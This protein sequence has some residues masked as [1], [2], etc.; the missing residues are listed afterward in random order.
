VTSARRTRTADDGAPSSIATTY[1]YLALAIGCDHPT[2][3]P[4]R[5]SLAD[6]SEVELSGAGQ[7]AASPPGS[8]LAI[9]CDDAWA[10]TRHARL[11]R[12][13]GRWLL[14]DLGSKN[15]TLVNGERITRRQLDDGDLIE[16]GRTTL[17]F[18]DVGGPAA[19]PART[20][21]EL[22]AAFVTLHLPLE[23]ALARAI[24]ALRAGLPVMVTGETGVGKERFVAASHAGAG[25]SG[26]LVAVNCAALPA[27]LV[28]AELFGHRRGAFSGA[29]EDRAGY[30]RAAH[31]GTVFL[32]EVGDMP[33]AA[34]AA[35]LR[36]LAERCVTPV[37]DERPI[38]VDLAVVSATHR[39]TAALV[40]DGRFRA[41][42]LARL[43]GLAIELPA[44]RDRREDI[45]IFVART[46]ARVAP[47]AT[48]QPPAMRALLTAPWP[49]NVRELEH[50]VAA[51]ALRAAPHP[52]GVAHLDGVPAA[53]P[54]HAP[55]P[56]PVA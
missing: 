27:A 3:R 52:I 31:R 9:S 35:V 34:Q 50:V 1:P 51:A 48:L 4:I 14:E 21:L 30:L 23:H 17:W 26:A 6:A 18:R 25:R 40:A 13:F 10:S 22:G 15:G 33:A 16:L 42:L 46:L 28:E 54:R 5:W 41:D 45:A 11:R 39:D 20:E 2:R 44:L 7:A 36:A 24:D 38:P 43:R 8:S 32:D 19:P 49:L 53:P 47:R 56:P 12:S 55:T 29:T 37:G